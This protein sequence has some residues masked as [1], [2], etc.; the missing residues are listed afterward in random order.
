MKYSLLILLSLNTWA[1]PIM[2]YHEEN[3]ESADQIREVLIREYQIPEDLIELKKV[4]ECA[5]LKDKGV[6][7]LCLKNNVDLDV[8]SVDRGFVNESLKIFRAP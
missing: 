2:I 8:V 5:V 7:D 3:Q 6:L 4:R 1:G